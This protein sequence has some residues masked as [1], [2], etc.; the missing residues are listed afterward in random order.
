[1]KAMELTKE[2]FLNKVADFE[3]EPGN[4]IFKGERPVVVDFYATWCGPCKMLSPIIE[5]LADEY[6]GRV[7]FYKVNT[8][9]AEDLSAAFN[10]RSIPSL[11]FVPKEGKPQM[12]VGALP[13]SELKKAIDSVLLGL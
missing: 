3:S 7:D 6:T 4:W 2:D 1:M 13:K 8:E 11:L 5:E 12:A 10:I 9:E